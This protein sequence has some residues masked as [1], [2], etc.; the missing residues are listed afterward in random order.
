MK[1]KS[2]LVIGG[3]FILLSLCLLL[4]KVFGVSNSSQQTYFIN[5][6][7]SSVPTGA[8]SEEDE[9][10]TEI[11]PLF[12]PEGWKTYSNNQWGIALAYPA[13]WRLVTT[14]YTISM[15]GDDY[16][17]HVG[18]AGTG[19]PDEAW[20]HPEYFI[21]GETANTWQAGSRKTGDGYQLIIVARGFQ[22]WIFTPDK[23]KEV[24]DQ[25]LS[26]VNLAE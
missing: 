1:A 10:R 18:I 4:M 5:T 24:S 12:V 23:S 25:I 6:V 9:T 26:T 7:T 22:F 21:D 14:P 15:R 8:V 16:D 19:L 17:I 20:T 3:V 2:I 11:Q 13:L